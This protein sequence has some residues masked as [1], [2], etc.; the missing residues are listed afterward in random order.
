M[1]MFFQV[2]YHAHSFFTPHQTHVYTPSL[3]DQHLYF[4]IVFIFNPVRSSLTSQIYS[5]KLFC[6]A[7]HC[8]IDGESTVYGMFQYSHLSSLSNGKCFSMQAP[9]VPTLEFSNY[10]TRHRCQAL[11]T[12]FSFHPQ[13]Y[14]FWILIISSKSSLWNDPQAGTFQIITIFCCWNH[15]SMLVCSPIF[16]RSQ[17]LRYSTKELCVQKI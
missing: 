3:S 17:A 11:H 1:I 10:L 6:P 7:T 13:N 14:D 9:S 4:A 15:E 8:C 12:K 5:Q 16:L 2:F